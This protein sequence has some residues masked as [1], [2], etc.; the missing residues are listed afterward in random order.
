MTP[1]AVHVARSNVPPG[2]IRNVFTP[3]RV[4]G[5]PALH[6]CGL[7]GRL[8]EV[9]RA[10]ADDSRGAVRLDEHGG[11]LIHCDPANRRG[12]SVLDDAPEED[13][14]PAEPIARDEVAVGDD[15]GHVR[16]RQEL[17]LDRHFLGV[18]IGQRLGRRDGVVHGGEAELP[19]H[20]Q[21]RAVPPIGT[22]RLASA[23]SVS[24]T[25]VPFQN[26]T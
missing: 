15:P 16:Q 21:A 3:R 9:G 26:F 6:A 22:P 4:N 14:K 7:L 8:H 23:L 18:R 25:G 12:P 11:L 17:P 24:C 13:E 10:L 5:V 2:G 19:H 1:A 20:R